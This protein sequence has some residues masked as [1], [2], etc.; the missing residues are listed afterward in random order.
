MTGVGFRD[1]RCQH[2]S[3]HWK[4]TISASSKLFLPPAAADS[5]VRAFMQA[6]GLLGSVG[7]M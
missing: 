5:H 7:S 6:V 3:L 1:L 2:V 4:H